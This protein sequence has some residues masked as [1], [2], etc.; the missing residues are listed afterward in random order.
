MLE[1]FL[2][3]DISKRYGELDLGVVDDKSYDA[4]CD[5]KVLQ[6]VDYLV[7]HVV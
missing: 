2:V 4:L 7:R 6:D 5:T 3:V 1:M